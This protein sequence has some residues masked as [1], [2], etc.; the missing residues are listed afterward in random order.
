MARKNEFTAEEVGKAIADANGIL[1][2]AARKLGCSRR[3]IHNYVNK[4]A[5]VKEVYA[6]ANETTIDF[7]EGKLMELIK[8]GNVTAIIFFLKT[9]A[10]HRGYV[11]RQ[12]HTGKDG[13]TINVKLVKHDD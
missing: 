4:Y 1:A 12:E 7:A 6:D 13:G 8:D 5:S 3:T 11:E 9:K 10:K 2:V